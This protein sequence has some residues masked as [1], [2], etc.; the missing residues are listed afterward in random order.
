MT[1]LDM[2]QLRYCLQKKKWFWKINPENHFHSYATRTSLPNSISIH[3]TLAGIDR[4]PQS[5]GAAGIYFNPRYPRR[6]RHGRRKTSVCYATFQSTIPSQVSTIRI[7]T[8]SW[9]RLYFNPRYPRRYRH[10][11]HFAWGVNM[12]NFNPRYP[13]RYRLQNCTKT[14]HSISSLCTIY[15]FF[16]HI[17][18]P[19]APY[20]TILSYFLCNISGANLPLIGCALHIRTTQILTHFKPAF[21]CYP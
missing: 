18:I 17:T 16:S 21:N 19:S 1:Y 3:D 13:R 12:Y 7:R 10:V 11:K 15:T 14:F 2:K 6:Y 5:A 8:S 20:I 4:Y 9:T